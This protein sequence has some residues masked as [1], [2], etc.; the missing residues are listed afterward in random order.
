METSTKTEDSGVDALVDKG[1][2]TNPLTHAEEQKNR[3]LTDSQHNLISKR[4]FMGLFSVYLIKKYV[5]IY[6]YIYIYTIYVEIFLRNLIFFYKL[7][8]PIHYNKK[9]T[10]DKD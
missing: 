10:K 4:S 1:K 9:L 5:Y 3:R 2:P 8:A 6:I 7:G